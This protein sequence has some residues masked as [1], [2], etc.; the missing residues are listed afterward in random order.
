[1]TEDDV[2]RII[3]EM[4]EKREEP[5]PSDIASIIA[6]ANREAIKEALDERE[7]EEAAEAEL[8]DQIRE[9]LK[10]ELKEELKAE[11]EAEA[12]ERAKKKAEDDEDEED[13]MGDGK[14]KK[15]KGMKGKRWEVADDASREEIEAAYEARAEVIEQFRSLLPKDYDTKGKSVHEVLVAAAGTE[16][17]DAEERSEDY[18][19]GR[20]EI[21]VERRQDAGEQHR[22]GGEDPS[23]PSERPVNIIQFGERRRSAS[24]AG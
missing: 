12:A 21:I 13:M 23:D 11:L 3:K 6:Q 15:R 5:A 10:A 8:R 24:A 17:E 18:L 2:K 20:L 7:A 9:E 1:M 22:A 16:I 14:K 4:T 19:L